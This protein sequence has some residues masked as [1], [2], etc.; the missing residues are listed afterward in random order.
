MAT[1][2]MARRF[3]GGASCSTG[4]P[5]CVAISCHGKK[6]RRGQLRIGGTAVSSPTQLFFIL[7]RLWWTGPGLT[8]V[9]VCYCGQERP[10]KKRLIRLRN[11]ADRLHVRVFLLSG[12][13]EKGCGWYRNG[14]PLQQQAETKGTVTSECTW[15]PCK[16]TPPDWLPC[17]LGP[18]RWVMRHA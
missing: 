13:W 5:N 10:F 3:S 16:A 15:P 2:N 11:R 6:G 14:M 12:R 4:L 18:H 9:L 1:W 17:L 8:G 7:Q